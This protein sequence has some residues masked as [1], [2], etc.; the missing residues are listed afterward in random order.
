MKKLFIGILVIFVATSVFAQNLT[1]RNATYANEYNLRAEQPGNVS[2]VVGVFWLVNNSAETANVQNV[3]FSLAGNN[4]LPQYIF[5][6]QVLVESEIVENDS[7]A[8]SIAGFDSAMITVHANIVGN[9]YQDHVLSYQLEI[10][11]KVSGVVENLTCEH[12]LRIF[13]APVTQSLYL[14]QGGNLI[15]FNVMPNTDNIYE[16]IPNLDKAWI[17]CPYSEK[18]YQI[19]AEYNLR[20][21]IRLGRGVFVRVYVD[22][23]VQLVGNP[24]H[25]LTFSVAPGWNLISGTYRATYIIDKDYLITAKY[26]WNWYDWYYPVELIN[27]SQAIWAYS[28]DYGIIATGVYPSGGNPPLAKSS[29]NNPPAPPWECESTLVEDNV[30]VAKSF[31]LE[32]NYPNPF[33]PTTTIAFSL[34][35]N[36]N[37]QLKIYNSTGQLV[38]TLTNQHLVAGN[39]EFVW[40]GTDENE[41]SISSGVYFYQLH[42]DKKTEMRRMLLMK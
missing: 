30:I 11:A 1:V 27:P 31:S 28:L 39:H 33:N 4:T 36:S 5:S 26:G 10:S 32:Q 16:L 34:S 13:D 38:K 7:A 40:K 19:G 35:Q 2:L 12:E 15:S 25:A 41:I 20:E 17:W 14:Q 42:T 6:S 18:Y 29:S 24:I 21:A 22:A 37:I 8:Y 3:K 23:E 9:I